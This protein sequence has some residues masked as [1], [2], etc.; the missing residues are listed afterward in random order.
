MSVEITT[1]IKMF[2]IVTKYIVCFIA[3]PQQNLGVFF[4]MGI[5]IYWHS[6]E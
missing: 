5:S 2:A 1:D 3:I 4:C 6:L